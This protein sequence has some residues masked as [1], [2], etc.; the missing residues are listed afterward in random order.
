MKKMK[1]SQNEIKLLLILLALVVLGATYQF[2]Y[3]KNLDK[4]EVLETE[5]QTLTTR[6]SELKTKQESGASIIAE[7]KTME[8]QIDAV[9]NSYGTGSTEEKSL[10]FIKGLEEASY[11]D[12]ST[13]NFSEPEYFLS[14]SELTVDATTNS[15][16]AQEETVE[17]SNETKI[18][19]SSET[20]IAVPED[21]A[22]EGITPYIDINT[23]SGYKSSLM[24]SFKVN[25]AGLMKCIEYINTYPEKINIGDI[26]L[27]FDSETGNL[28]GSMTIQMYNIIGAGKP[29]TEPTIGG[30][31]I[32]IDN[33]FGTIELPIQ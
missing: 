21:V 12:I 22:I 15:E 5:T 16:I 33:I 24:I 11:M 23:I 20:E 10:I 2:I 27:A 6:L 17:E 18:E 9:I 32:G 29:Y 14:A 30:V 31:N 8:Q 3:K 19:T 25:Y 26:T 4:I 1:I 13:V 28:T 7:N